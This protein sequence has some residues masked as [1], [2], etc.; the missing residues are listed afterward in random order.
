MKRFF[1]IVLILSL[2][3]PIYHLYAQTSNKDIKS[4]S[5]NIPEN[6]S[7]T[8]NLYIDVHEVGPGKLTAEGVAAAHAKD[9]A[10][11]KKYGVDFIKYWVDTAQGEVYCLSLASDSNAIVKTHAEA[12]G[13]LPTHIYRVNEGVEA[14]THGG[15]YLFLD[16]HELGPGNVKAADV[17][18]AH[19]K[20]L[21]VEKKYGVNFVNY[22]VDERKGVVMCLSEAPDSTSI[23]NTHKEAHGL[24]PKYVLSVKQGQ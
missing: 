18:A 15:N 12:H 9:L 8:R 4:K 21:A 10:T 17:A 2:S 6:S 7:A 23:I 5:F 22:W 1:Q 16:V 24:I 13:L 3:L 19:Q 11:E 20:D 14:K